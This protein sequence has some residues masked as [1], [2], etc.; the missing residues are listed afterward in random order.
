MVRL[1]VNVASRHSHSTGSGSLGSDALGSTQ[2]IL[3]EKHAR[4]AFAEPTLPWFVLPCQKRVWHVYESQTSHVTVATIIFVNFALSA[5]KAQLLAEEGTH[6]F[7]AFVVIEWSFNFIFLF[8]LLVNM[9]A[10]FCAAFWRSG[11]NIFDVIIVL[12][13]WMS[14]LFPGLPGITVLRLFRAFRVFRLF[15][16]IPSLRMI[17]AGCL[18]SLPGIS[19]AFVVLGFVMG[20]WG[21]M[22]VTMFG[23]EFPTEFGTFSRGIL[24]CIQMMTYDSWVSGVTRPI[25]L[26]YGG[27]APPLYFISYS[28]IS[29]IIMANVLVAILVDKYTEAVREM[30]EQDERSEKETVQDAIN[31]PLAQK[32]RHA[33]PEV[34]EQ[35]TEAQT[36][37]SAQLLEIRQILEETTKIAQRPKKKSRLIG[38]MDALEFWTT[39]RC[40]LWKQ[41]WLKGWFESDVVQIALSG[42]IFLNFLVA[43]VET[44]ICPSWTP[45]QDNLKTTF[46]IIEIS[47]N[48]FFALE[49]AT[50]M[51]ANFLV[52]FYRCP[53]NIMDAVIVLFSITLA[54]IDRGVDVTSLRV[55]RAFRRTIVAFR[56]VKL[57]RLDWVRMIV[58]GV[59]KALPGVLNAFVLLGLVM[60]IWSIM[61]VNFYA[62]DHPDLFGNFGLSMLTMMQIMSFDSWSSQI[63]RPVILQEGTWEEADKGVAFGGIIFFLS[64]VFASAI[65]MANVVLA[66][67]I[68]K[69]LTAAREF[70][71]EQEQEQEL[72]ALVEYERR[73]SFEAQE[74]GNL[75]GDGS[76]GNAL[77]A[78]TAKGGQ[79]EQSGDSDLS[80]AAFSRIGKCHSREQSGD[81]GL[82]EG[83]APQPLSVRSVSTETLGKDMIAE[84][85]LAREN[86]GKIDENQGSST[87]ETREETVLHILQKVDPVLA[88]GEAMH[89]EL[90]HLAD[91]VRGPLRV[92]VRSQQRRAYRY[93][94]AG[95]LQHPC[96]QKAP[97]VP[98]MP[99]KLPQTHAPQEEETAASFSEEERS[100]SRHCRQDERCPPG[101]LGG[102]C[103]NSVSMVHRQ[104]S[105]SRTLF[106]VPKE[107]QDL[108]E[109]ILSELHGGPRE[110]SPTPVG[111]S[112][113]RSIS[114]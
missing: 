37:L 70:L 65:I 99:L 96:G 25:V 108:S 64:Y 106:D 18:K 6:T 20:I 83:Q 40:K 93:K 62:P 4:T 23:Q 34:R 73:A 45:D 85:S 16:R 51:Y 61:A 69:F 33:S 35:L 110:T 81:S 113:S 29:A 78:L 50:N 90:F 114:L 44:Q 31:P 67:L 103:G 13:S 39:T 92:F 49:L 100:R 59:L 5:L 1:I 60:G 76:P 17:I 66:I 41:G 22:G 55:L 7:F 2:A 72:A 46:E 75:L 68:D 53:W 112:T 57:L 52:P 21:I 36:R 19:N 3:A 71:E 30:K 111:L 84:Y 24:T 26:Y 42:V 56:V 74:Q 102:G 48:A 27:P 11:W 12:V 63:T 88:F 9:Y 32:P 101:S 98:P 47:F 38:L 109:K 91:Y 10:N 94:T 97:Q 79:L 87:E 86:D 95:R 58:L 14:Q 105:P 104:V 15:K 28:F 8:E 82:S 43:A 89:D 77:T 107:Y 54:F 80:E